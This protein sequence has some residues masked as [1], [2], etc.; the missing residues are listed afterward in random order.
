MRVCMDNVSA[1]STVKAAIK[2]LKRAVRYGKLAERALAD[3]EAG[4]PVDRKVPVVYANPSL[5]WKASEK[6]QR[7]PTI[8]LCRFPE[9]EPVSRNDIPNWDSLTIEIGAKEKGTHGGM[10]FD[11]VPVYLVGTGL[12][13]VKKE[14]NGPPT[15]AIER[16]KLAAPLDRALIGRIRLLNKKTTLSVRGKDGNFSVVKIS[17]HNSSFIAHAAAH[18]LCRWDFFDYMVSADATDHVPQRMFDIRSNI[19]KWMEE[20]GT[21][22]RL[23]N[24]LF[25]QIEVLK[26][27]SS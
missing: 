20:D 8:H 2:A 7:H 13:L 24:T 4:K 26:V 6:I 1:E 23:V 12:S 25:D 5:N 18:L 11:Q 19:P 16:K 15:A 14:G 21:A 17:R 3:L 9:Y 10:T 27:M 22:M